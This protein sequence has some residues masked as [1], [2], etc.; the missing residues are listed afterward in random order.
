MKLVLSL[1]LE[2]HSWN[3][4]YAN[5]V[6]NK[7]LYW[8]VKFLHAKVF[9]RLKEE[10]SSKYPPLL[11]PLKIWSCST[12][13]TWWYT[14]NIFNLVF[15]QQQYYLCTFVCAFW[16]FRPK[17]IFYPWLPP[18]CWK[19]Q[20]PKLTIPTATALTTT[21]K[22]NLIFFLLLR[23]W[24]GL[25]VAGPVQYRP[26][27]VYRQTFTVPSFSLGSVRCFLQWE[28]CTHEGHSTIRT[29]VGVFNRIWNGPS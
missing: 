9:L 1:Q 2:N 17:V 8:I 21:R 14:L 18:S 7:L 23:F 26:S 28:R 10:N 13:K 24:R 20:R 19:F 25:A 11:S 6:A 16:L 5:K 4:L 12:G 15:S 22:N 27:A 29:A 3:W